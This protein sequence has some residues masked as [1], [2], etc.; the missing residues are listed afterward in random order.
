MK[1]TYVHIQPSYKLVDKL[2]CSERQSD[3]KLDEFSEL[4]YELMNKYEVYRIDAQ[5]SPYERNIELIS[6][7]QRQ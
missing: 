1:E 6:K 5:L 7:Y 3:E 4:L 2:W